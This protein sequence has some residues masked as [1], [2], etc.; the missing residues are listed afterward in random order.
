MLNI[1]YSESHMLLPVMA[2]DKGPKRREL[3]YFFKAV[4]YC[5][6]TSVLKI[7]EFYDYLITLNSELDRL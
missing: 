6:F 5:I 3:L 7:N 4:L 2:Y 1:L